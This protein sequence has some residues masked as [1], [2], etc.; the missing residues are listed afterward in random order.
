MNSNFFCIISVTVAALFFN[1]NTD[2]GPNTDKKGGWTLKWEEN[3]GQTNQFDSKYWSKIPRGTS[4]WNKYM[5]DYDGCYS[6]AD[7]N[8]VLKGLINTTC[9]ND[10]APYITGGVFTKGKFSIREGKI[11]IRAK[12]QNAKG[13]WPAIW[14]L[15]DDGAKWPD[16][17]EIDIM[18]R[19]NSDSKAYQTTH[20]YYT[21]TLK[22]YNNPKHGSTGPINPEG[23]NEYSVIIDKDSLTYLIN[24]KVIIVYPRIKT[25]KQGQFP[26]SEHPYYLLIDMQLGGDWVGPIDP[27]DLPV[28][29]KVD[30]VKYYLRN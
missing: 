21:E 7:G 28:E 4:P 3:F 1:C 30:W 8:L 6:M 20:S 29:M 16:G 9:P 22:Q 18:E 19:L 11:T 26:F 24:D 5:T 17:G 27:K 25:D 10:T 23:Y 12:L 13:A 2:D 14:M 15:P